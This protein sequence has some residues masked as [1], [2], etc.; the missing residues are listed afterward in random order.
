[1]E[2]LIT[3]PPPLEIWEF[4]FTFLDPR[5][6][7]H[8]VRLVCHVWYSLI[9][10]PMSDAIAKEFQLKPEP[11][12]Y[13][14]YVQFHHCRAATLTFNQTIAIMMPTEIWKALRKHFTDHGWTNTV[15][16]GLRRNGKTSAV[17]RE[18]FRYALYHPRKRIHLVGFGFREYRRIMD[19]LF[20]I[21]PHNENIVRHKDSIHF[22]NGSTLMRYKNIHTKGYIPPDFVFLHDSFMLFSDR[23]FERVCQ[24][25]LSSIIV[26]CHADYKTNDQPHIIKYIVGGKE[27]VFHELLS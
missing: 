26:V 7:F 13:N 16:N 24:T 10:K 4:I 9:K 18:T 3:L 1:M 5:T 8:S 25:F 14:D 21:I 11:F 6:L 27:I 2:P 23:I 12:R 15:V 19:Q 17:I 20:A 22:T